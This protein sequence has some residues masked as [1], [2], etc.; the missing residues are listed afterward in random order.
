MQAVQDIAI[1]RAYRLL[2]H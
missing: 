1:A 2:R